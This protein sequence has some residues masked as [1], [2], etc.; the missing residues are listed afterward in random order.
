M[1]NKHFRLVVQALAAAS[2]CTNFRAFDTNATTPLRNRQ[3][4][5]QT[6]RTP[7]AALL[8]ENTCDFVTTRA[9]SSIFKIPFT[10][11]VPV[12]LDE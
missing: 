8:F 6:A 11:F 4:Y 7:I 3:S 12:A 2:A 9:T 10:E 1:S 5:R